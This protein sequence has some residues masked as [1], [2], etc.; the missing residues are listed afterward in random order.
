MRTLY[1][2]LEKISPQFPFS[3]VFVRRLSFADKMSVNRRDIPRSAPP[4]RKMTTSD[5][6]RDLYAQGGRAY[7]APGLSTMDGFPSQW[8][9]PNWGYWNPEIRHHW[10]SSHRHRFHR[11]H[12]SGRWRH[13]HSDGGSVWAPEYEPIGSFGGKNKKS[14]PHWGGDEET[15]TEGALIRSTEQDGSQSEFAIA[16]STTSQK[17]DDC[18]MAWILVFV[19]FVIILVG[20]I[21]WVVGSCRRGRGC[22]S[23]HK[24][25]HEC[26]CE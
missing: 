22:A 26:T 21:I 13:H 3:S 14:H 6:S 17:T 20:L 12:N 2:G 18:S 19:L 23:C 1:Q 5:L 16:T 7:Y 4:P 11:D 15:V 8:L 9:P 10:W 24:P 25:I